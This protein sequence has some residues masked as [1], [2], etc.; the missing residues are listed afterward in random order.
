MIDTSGSMNTDDRINLAKQAAKSVLKTLTEHDY[1][2]VIEFNSMANIWTGNLDMQP[3]TD[4]NK[5]PDNSSS[6][7]TFID[8][9]GPV[10][11]TNFTDAFQKA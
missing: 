8:N 2:T 10:G 5:D 6:A 3:M 1:A 11:G 4:A 9:L 7:F